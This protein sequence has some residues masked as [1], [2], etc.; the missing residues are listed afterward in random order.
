MDIYKEIRPQQQP[1]PA[2][3]FAQDV[4]DETEMI[5]QDVHKNTLQ[6]YIKY[7]SYYDKIANASNLKEV[8]YVYVSQPKTDHQGSNVPLTEIR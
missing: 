4:R 7:K 2:S 6:A 5:Q 8:D 1:I 3:Q